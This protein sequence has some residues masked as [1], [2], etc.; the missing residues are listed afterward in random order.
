MSSSST[1]KPSNNNSNNNTNNNP[2]IDQAI[3]SCFPSSDSLSSST[4]DAIEYI[5]ANFPD[6][7]SLFGIETFMGSL[8][9][10][11]TGK[12]SLIYCLSLDTATA[13]AIYHHH[14]ILFCLLRNLEKTKKR[15]CKEILGI[16]TNI[17]ACIHAFT[18]NHR[19]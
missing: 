3:A 6:E 11:I 9:G 17:R 14:F 16:D 8:G 7:S 10:K 2:S 12:S 5:N 4:F 19:T 13:I 18:M 15:M 1:N